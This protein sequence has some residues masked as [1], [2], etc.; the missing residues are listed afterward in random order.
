[1]TTITFASRSFEL[2]RS[3]RIT[4]KE[5]ARAYVLHDNDA[6]RRSAI[7]AVAA[8][9]FEYEWR[10][11]GGPKRPGFTD[12]QMRQASLYYEALRRERAMP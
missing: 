11:A 10:Q 3:H 4:P 5:A 1:M 9:R 6:G 8:P 12:E 2:I 7:E